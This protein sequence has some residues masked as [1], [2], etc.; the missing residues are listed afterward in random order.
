MAE[1]ELQL[2][3]FAVVND[4][5]QLKI[6]VTYKNEKRRFFPEEIISMI[7]VKMKEVAENYLGQPVREAVVTVPSCFNDSQV[8]C[9]Q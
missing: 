1:N 6:E 5:G 9:N 3:P 7:L 8:R 4:Q 2:R